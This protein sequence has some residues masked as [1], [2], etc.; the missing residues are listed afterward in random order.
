MEGSSYV[1]RVSALIALI[2]CAAF[3]NLAE[4]ALLSVNRMVL[5]RLREE[6]DPRARVAYRLLEDPGQL[7]TTLL[8]GNT[9]ANVGASVLATSVALSLLGRRGGEW[10]AFLGTILL[11]LIVA[12]IAPKTLAVRHADRVA[13]WVAGPVSAVA[14]VLTPLIRFLS[15]LA[16]ALI[17]PFGAT[18]TTRAPLVTEEQLR[19]LVQVGEE[20]GVIEEAEREMIHSIFEFGDTLVREVMRPRI[21]IVAIP[22][23]ATINEALGLIMEH[24][25]SRLPV[26]EGSVDHIVGVVYIKDLLP[27]IRQGRLDQPVREVSRPPF[28]VPE[29]KKVNDLFKELQRRKVSMAIVLDEYG[30]TAGLVTMEDLLEEI[31][32]EIQDEYDLEEKPIQL[33][34][35]R[36]AVV[37]ARTPIHEVNEALDLQL[38]SE[39]VDTIAGLVYTLFGRV[40]A[41]GEA[42]T[43]DG[44]ELRVEKT[45]G[46]RITKVRITRLPPASSPEEP[47]L[48]RRTPTSSL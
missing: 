39:D 25:H 43:V 16:T 32:G 15:L 46:Q 10:A 19:F 26:Y 41:Q 11:L 13:L 29:T 40:P 2:L 37:N 18:V 28:F 47:T 27:A 14:R 24:G 34:D 5:R 35:D 36:T 12:E 20:E 4:G 33:I 3:F 21:D 38:P 23:E 42:V 8:A 22:A 45:L 48:S 30:G 7:L 9:I 1:T 31:V 6:G 44:T 17:R